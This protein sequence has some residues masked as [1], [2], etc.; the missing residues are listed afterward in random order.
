MFTASYREETKN[1]TETTF[2]FAL[3]YYWT[4]K[5]LIDSLINELVKPQLEPQ[6]ILFPNV[7]Y[8]LL[9]FSH[10]LDKCEGFFL[11]VQND[12]IEDN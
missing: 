1:P 11:K 2:L 4:R 3:L 7:F 12:L 10:L 8:V 5:L 9:S 6:Q